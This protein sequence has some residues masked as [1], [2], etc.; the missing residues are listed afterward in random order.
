MACKGNATAW[1]RGLKHKEGDDWTKIPTEDEE[2]GN[3]V[4]Q[5]IMNIRCPEC[6]SLKNIEK[7]K[8]FGKV[9]FGRIT[10]MKCK[11]AAK[12][13]RWRCSCDL[14]WHKCKKHILRTL[15]HAHDCEKG[16]SMGSKHVIKK[17][18]KVKLQGTNNPHPKRRG[19]GKPENK[20][21]LNSLSQG[22]RTIMKEGSILA[23]RFR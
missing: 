4:K 22:T 5:I 23:E 9:G 13:S 20:A 18:N 6:G 8:V 1:M 21:S 19:K 16:C 14:L 17:V 2:E 15:M 10:C 7:Y 12:A 11:R 3:I